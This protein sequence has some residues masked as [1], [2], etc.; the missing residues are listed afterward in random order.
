MLGGYVLDYDERDEASAESFPSS[1]PPANGNDRP[2]V[3]NDGGPS[4]AH[5]RADAAGVGAGSAASAQAGA[6]ATAER[7][8]AGA[9]TAAAAPSR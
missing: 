3:G 8:A 9:G 6:T 2:V 5:E 1:D 7:G 4:Y